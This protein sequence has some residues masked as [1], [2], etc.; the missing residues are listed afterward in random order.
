MIDEINDNMKWD[1]RWNVMWNKTNEIVRAT[2]I[3]P[4][5]VFS[6]IALLSPELLNGN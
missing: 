1:D 6:S 2:L 5:D 3:Y 4:E